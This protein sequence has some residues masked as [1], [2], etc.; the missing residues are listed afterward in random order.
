MDVGTDPRCLPLPRRCKLT[1]TP[2]TYATLYLDGLIL[3]SS[4]TFT[5]NLETRR[6]PGFWNWVALYDRKA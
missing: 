3:P 4:A 1:S 6:S 5:T 2:W